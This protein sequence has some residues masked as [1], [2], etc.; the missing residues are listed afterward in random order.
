MV[1]EKEVQNLRAQIFV[2]NIP[3]ANHAEDDRAS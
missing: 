1:W 3:D 2:E